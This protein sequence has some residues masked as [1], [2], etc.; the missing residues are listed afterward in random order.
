M[1]APRTPYGR[2][3]RAELDRLDRLCSKHDGKSVSSRRQS[4]Q[5]LL[6]LDDDD[7]AL[8]GP[9]SAGAVSLAVVGGVAL[10]PIPGPGQPAGMTRRGFLTRTALI[11]GGAVA[12]VLLSGE[13][14]RAE[15]WFWGFVAKAA[16]GAVI[17]WFV[18]KV[19]D[20]AWK[21]IPERSLD[22]VRNPAPT[23]NV[24]HN[25]FATPYVI[26]NNGYHVKPVVLRAYGASVGTGRFL[27]TY[28]LN[29]PEAAQVKRETEGGVFTKPIVP[30][31]MRYAPKEKHAKVIRKAADRYDLRA[32]D[33]KADYVDIF[34]DNKKKEHYGVGVS[35][36]KKNRF[37]ALDED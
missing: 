22:V 33:Y 16:F 21:R 2:T 30:T 24:H 37:L 11:G 34:T 26:T 32:G 29:Y 1:S 27:L 14:Q 31:T 17:G 4:K 18:N 10:S 28:D 19:L 3:V 6:R 23:R 35:I 5:A 7:F 13:E 36:G 9:A 12:G 8:F 25:S 20:T 15:A